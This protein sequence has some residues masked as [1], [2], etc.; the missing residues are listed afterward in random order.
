MREDDAKYFESLP[1][2]GCVDIYAITEETIRSKWYDVDLICNFL[3]I[4]PE[5]NQTR[6]GLIIPEQVKE[7]VPRKGVVVKSGEITEEYKTYPLSWW[8]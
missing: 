2:N 1:T 7:G 5:V 4:E 6:S 8:R 3:G